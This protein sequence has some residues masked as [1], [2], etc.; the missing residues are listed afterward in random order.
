[1]TKKTPPPRRPVPRYSFRECKLLL[2]EDNEDARKMLAK[3]LR[4]QGFEV[5]EA[6]DGRDA[7]EQIHSFQ[8][9]V[10]VIDIGLPVM[11][12]YR[13][14]QE[15]RKI[16]TLSETTLIALTGYG[17]ES[18]RRAAMDA[19]FDA[20]L[21]KPLNPTELYSLIATRVPAPAAAAGSR[22]AAP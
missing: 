21:V 4:L 10:A 7:L 3:S 5:A 14:V 16:E 11:D 2:V 13:L 6:G 9:D 8:P 1:M 17:R 20:H 22:D 18:D 19:G 15:I 12:G